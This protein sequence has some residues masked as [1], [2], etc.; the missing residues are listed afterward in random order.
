MCMWLYLDK[1][2]GEVNIMHTSTT[3]L[4][5]ID[6]VYLGILIIFA[7]DIQNNYTKT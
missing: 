2:Y 3:L 7:N 6:K 5:Y 4:S 1:E